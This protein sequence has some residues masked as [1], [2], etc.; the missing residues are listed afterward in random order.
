M[1]FFYGNRIWRS[2]WWNDKIVFF[3]DV[4][5]YMYVKVF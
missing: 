3:I 1:I 5:E 4:K 2:N